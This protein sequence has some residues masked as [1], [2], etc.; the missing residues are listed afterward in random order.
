M[1]LGLGTVG[2]G[3]VRLDTHACDLAP[4]CRVRAKVWAVAGFPETKAQCVGPV[5]LYNWKILRAT[6]KISD[7]E[8]GQ[9]RAHF[10]HILVS[11]LFKTP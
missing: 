8:P 10:L 4:I 11:A 2:I 9:P 1:G 7:S 5:G 3:H 6:V